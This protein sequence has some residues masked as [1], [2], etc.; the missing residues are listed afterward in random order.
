LPGLWSLA[1]SDFMWHACNPFAFWVSPQAKA[2]HPLFSW[3]R[4][5][6]PPAVAVHSILD[7]GEWARQ[8]GSK[9]SASHCAGLCVGVGLGPVGHEPTVMAQ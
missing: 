6:H 8:K 1:A 7:S 3:H 9:L 2:P 4:V 5:Q